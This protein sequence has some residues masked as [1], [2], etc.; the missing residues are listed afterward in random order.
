MSNEF[1]RKE[2][3]IISL[4]LGKHIRLSDSFYVKHEFISFPLT[5][6]YTHLS[7]ERLSCFQGVKSHYRQ[8][9]TSPPLSFRFELLCMDRDSNKGNKSICYLH[10]SKAGLW[11]P[12]PL[13]GMRSPWWRWHHRV[14]ESFSGRYIYFTRAPST[15]K[16]EYLCSHSLIFFW[17]HTSHCVP[18]TISPSVK[19]QHILPSPT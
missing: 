13:T 10:I 7:Q 4:I 1:F 5:C 15:N 17:S 11:N 19:H 12:V 3:W 16:M 2:V 9:W 18:I 6:H 8:I 14:R